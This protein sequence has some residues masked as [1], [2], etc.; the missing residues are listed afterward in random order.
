MCDGPGF[1]HLIKRLVEGGTSKVHFNGLFTFEIKFQWEVRHGCLNSLFVFALTTQPLM[2]LLSRSSQQGNFVRL[3][4]EPRR[5]LLHQLFANDIGIFL[6]SIE[7]NFLKATSLISVYERI[8]NVV[9]NLHKSILIELNPRAQA[10]WF[11]NASC[12]V[13]ARGRSIVTWV[14]LLALIFPMIR[15]YDSYWAWLERNS[16]IIAIGSFL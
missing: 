15:F 16:G 14:A 12:K 10:T 3:T 13:A 7:A 6:K 9:L 1:I 11:V 2:S 5:Q 8:S 4:V